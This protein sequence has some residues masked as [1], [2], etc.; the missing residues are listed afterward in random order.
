VGEIHPFLFYEP[1]G[2]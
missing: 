2:E 1:H